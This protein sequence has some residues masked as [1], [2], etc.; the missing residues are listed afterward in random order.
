[1]D[2][3]DCAAYDGLFSTATEYIPALKKILSSLNGFAGRISRNP[4]HLVGPDQKSALKDGGDGQY[5]SQNSKSQGVVRNSFIG[6]YLT[7]FLVGFAGGLVLL[8][9][10][11][12]VL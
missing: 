6:Q 4:S 7:G 10:L 5:T 8:C 2:Q 3:I 9:V 11:Y 12:V 1:L